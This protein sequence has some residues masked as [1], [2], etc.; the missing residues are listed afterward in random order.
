MG[1]DLDVLAIARGAL[2]DAAVHRG[3][4]LGAAEVDFGLGHFGAGGGDLRF[5]A[6]DLGIQ[7]IDL[8]ALG[9]EVG[10][11]L[12]DLGTCHAG[13][14]GQGGDPLFRDIAGLA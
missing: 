5:Q 3:A 2:A 12:G 13:V 11:G 9:L 1:A 4:D 10:L 8:L 14:G 7:G 6:L